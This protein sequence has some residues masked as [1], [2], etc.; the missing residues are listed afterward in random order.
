MCSFRDP[1]G[2]AFFHSSVQFREHCRATVMVGNQ[3]ERSAEAVNEFLNLAGCYR[4]SC[5]HKC[6][7]LCLSCRRAARGGGLVNSKLVT[8]AFSAKRIVHVLVVQKL[9]ER[10]NMLKQSVYVCLAAMANK[11]FAAN[12]IDS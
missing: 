10:I 9:L 2:R 3:L 12:D 6:I 5:P 7:K 1:S 4:F 8:P 11:V